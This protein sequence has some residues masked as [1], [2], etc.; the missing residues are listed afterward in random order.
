MNS[1]YGF[2]YAANKTDTM[3]VSFSILSNRFNHTK[4]TDTR[5]TH[6]HTHMKVHIFVQKKSKTKECR[7]NFVFCLLLLR[8][9]YCLASRQRTEEDKRKTRKQINKHK[10]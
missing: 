8:N 6:S 7:E 5:H 1:S 9:T 2:N 3:T 4:Q 10:K